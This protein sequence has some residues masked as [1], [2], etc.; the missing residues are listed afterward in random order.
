MK[1]Y[2][3]GNGFDIAHGIRCKYSDFYAYL[4][5][6]RN[7]VL[8]VMEK[9]Y[10]ID[11]TSDLWF[12]FEEQLEA[13]ISYDS[14]KNIILE[15]APDLSSDNFR[16]ADW[17]TSQFIIEQ[18]CDNLLANIRSGFEEWINSLDLD[19]IIEKYEIDRNAHFFSFNYTEVLEQVYK[20]PIA[21]I[22]HIHNKVGEKLVFGH[23]KDVDNFNVKKALYGN[24]NAYIAID[25][26]TGAIIST[27]DGHEQFAEMAVCT[28]YDSMRKHTEE[29]I[30][31]HTNYFKKL[32]NIDEILVIGHSYN[33]TDHP[34]FE[35]ISEN[36]SD[37]ASWTLYYFSS[38][39]RVNAEKLMKKLRINNNLLYYK[40]CSEMEKRNDAH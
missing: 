15:N 36:V 33:E 14:L 27:E 25:E 29:I 13:N 12:K 16:D 30:K 22:L 2:I 7:E 1:L 10:D 31:N 37:R 4:T 18:E 11:E 8:E 39:D 28:F 23:G 6:N 24:E 26:E 21:N 9:Y 35:I 32:A 17:Y 38:E 40:H 34:Y 20:I 19:S 3:I 5:E